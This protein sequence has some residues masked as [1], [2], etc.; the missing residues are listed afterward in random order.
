MWKL[1]TGSTVTWPDGSQ[2]GNGNPGV[3]AIVKA[4]D[5][6]I[7]YVDYSDAKA[8]GLKFG[9]VQN[10]AGQVHHPERE[11]GDRGAR[12]REPGGRRPLR[13]AE[14]AE[15]GGVPDHRADVAARVHR[16]TRTPTRPR[17]VKAWAEYLIGGC[18]KQAKSIDYAPLPKTLGRRRPRPGSDGIA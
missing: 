9:S 17:P 2:G 16:S 6:A 1:G 15:P 5:G 18:Q 12:G 7:G 11:G 13:P 4:T 8:T 3:S 14:L 10:A